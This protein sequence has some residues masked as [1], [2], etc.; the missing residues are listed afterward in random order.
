[1]IG[2]EECKELIR[3]NFPQVVIQT[4][5]PITHGWDSFVLDVNGEL[6]FRFPM[7]TVLIVK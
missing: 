3:R 2:I 1:M 6:I 5:R 7:C 4:A